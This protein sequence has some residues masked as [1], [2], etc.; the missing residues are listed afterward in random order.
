VHMPANG[1]NVSMRLLARSISFAIWTWM[2]CDGEGYGGEAV[3]FKQ[4]NSDGRGCK[5]LFNYYHH[6]PFVFHT[7]VNGKAVK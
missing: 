5:T 3:V 2:R 6:R 7:G 4:G 1:T